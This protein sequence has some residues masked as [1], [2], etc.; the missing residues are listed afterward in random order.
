M[1][2]TKSTF[3]SNPTLFLVGLPLLLTVTNAWWIVTSI[4]LWWLW[5]VSAGN[6]YPAYLLHVVQPYTQPSVRRSLAIFGPLLALALLAKPARVYEQWHF[7]LTHLVIGAVVFAFKKAP[8]F[9]VGRVEQSVTDTLPHFIVHYLMPGDVAFE[10]EYAVWKQRVEACEQQYQQLHK[11]SSASKPDYR[12]VVLPPHLTA[13][14]YYAH[15]HNVRRRALRHLMWAAVHSVISSLFALLTLY[16]HTHHPQLL[17]W[18]LLAD[19]LACGMIVGACCFM[20]HCVP[21]VVELAHGDGIHVGAM[22]D[23]VIVSQTLSEFWRRW[24][25]G[26]RDVFF[27]C[28]YKPLGGRKNHIVSGLVV[29]LLSGCLH[30][31]EVWINVGHTRLAMLRFFLLQV[32]G[33]IAERLWQRYRPRRYALPAWCSWLTTAAWLLVTSHYFILDFGVGLPVMARKALN[34]WMVPLGVDFASVLR[35]LGTSSAEIARLTVA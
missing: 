21:A 1:S 35:W 24:N 19:G 28:V 32:L 13:E 8:E 2:A 16:L 3:P 5:F 6:V 31:Y 11:A 20:F 14:Q 10:E 27:H 17:Q 15:F 25:R 30:E 12:T 26:M 22:W 33:V 7:E 18:R 9:A 4:P 23:R 34:I 29:G